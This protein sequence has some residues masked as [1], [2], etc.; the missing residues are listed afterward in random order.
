MVRTHLSKGLGFSKEDRDTNIMR[1]GY[2]AN[3]LTRK[4]GFSFF[5]WDAGDPA[6]IAHAAGEFASRKLDAL[7]KGRTS[8]EAA[9]DALG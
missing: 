3:L 8:G 5:P 6:E 1:I 9:I 7:L 2:V 4:M